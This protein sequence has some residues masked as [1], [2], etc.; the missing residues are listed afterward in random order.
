M[1]IPAPLPG[2][3]ADP[4]AR[5]IRSS[6]PIRPV[7]PNRLVRTFLGLALGL[8]ALL[9]ALLAPA[10]ALAHAELA[11]I[12]PADTSTVQGSPT[13][14]V[15]TFTEDLDA[16]ASSLKIVDA[17][18]KVIVEGS[19]VGSDKTTMTLPVPA[20]LAPGAYTVRWT[21][22]SSADGDLDHGTTTFTVAAAP[23]SAPSSAASDA[24][25]SVPTVG[26]SVA[27][28]VA[29][30]TA[31]ATP[32][33]STGDAIIPIVVVLIALAGLGLWFLRGRGRAR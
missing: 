18:G 20:I 14:I 27:P 16:G 25:S 3:I 12:D 22:K 15:A 28:T 21:S 10:T 29:P 30:S 23:S 19:A 32:A 26:P 24:P 17:S 13:K 9:A 6:R 5:P 2:A 31:P 4:G 1:S 7:R 8:A 33:T 11:T